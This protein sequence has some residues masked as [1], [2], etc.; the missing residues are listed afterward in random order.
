MAK[1]S[2]NGGRFSIGEAV[3]RLKSDYPDL[4]ISKLRYLEDEGLLKLVRSKGGYRLFSEADVGRLA[5]ILR[6]QKE[7]FLP[8]GVIKERMMD[9]QPGEVI[10]TDAGLDEPDAEKPVKLHDALRKTGVSIDN[11]KAIES[12][13]LITL[14]DREGGLV[15]APKDFEVLRLFSKLSKFGIEPR[16]MRMF[17]NQAQRESTLIQQILA[18]QLRN[19]NEKLRRKGEDDLN[20]LISLTEKIKRLALDRALSAVNLRQ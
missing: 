6:L 16:H 18:P 11:V 5:E 12:F 15:L 7:Q 14:T 2:E 13:G 4:S 3:N 10:E 20:T 19:K 8:L 1:K 17:E 9:W